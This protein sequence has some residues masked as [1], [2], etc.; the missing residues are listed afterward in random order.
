LTQLGN[1]LIKFILV[2]VDGLER[3]LSLTLSVL[4][5]LFRVAVSLLGCEQVAF[6]LNLLSGSWRPRQLSAP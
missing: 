5:P 2:L 3:G 1:G 6:D 4:Q